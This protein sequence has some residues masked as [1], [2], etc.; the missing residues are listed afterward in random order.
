MK[1]FTAQV[2]GI[3]SSGRLERDASC[4]K[5]LRLFLKPFGC[6]S[7]DLTQTCRPVSLGQQQPHLECSLHSLMT[8]PSV[9]SRHGHEGTSLT[10]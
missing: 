3:S 1:G 6:S 10:R 2:S 8:L 4:P 7:A 5:R 9:I